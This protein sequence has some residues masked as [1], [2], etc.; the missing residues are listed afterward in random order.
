MKNEIESDEVQDLTN[1]KFYKHKIIEC[2]K[3]HS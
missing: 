3:L 1:F 2:L